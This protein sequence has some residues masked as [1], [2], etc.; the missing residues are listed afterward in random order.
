MV[1]E[2]NLFLDTIK[3]SF[4]KNVLNIKPSKKSRKR[5]RSKKK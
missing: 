4:E 1:K 2:I 5:R 3:H